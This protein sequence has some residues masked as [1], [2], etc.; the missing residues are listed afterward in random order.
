M[1]KQK[2]P[3]QTTTQDYFLFQLTFRLCLFFLL[4]LIV[5]LLFYV[6]GNFQ[7]L[8]DTTQHFILVLSSAVS[9]ALVLFTVIGT[10]ESIVCLCIS[11]HRKYWGYFFFFLIVAVLSAAVLVFLRTVTFISAGL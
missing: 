9:I 2:L 1:N 8:L 10:V 11:K 7:Q 3:K 6:V 4:F 5:M